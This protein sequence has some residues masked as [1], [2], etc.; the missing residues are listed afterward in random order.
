MNLFYTW[1]NF[2]SSSSVLIYLFETH[3]IGVI[4]CFK[5]QNLKK[6]RSDGCRVKENQT[7]VEKI[8]KSIENIKTLYTSVIQ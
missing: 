2:S 4:L 3:S 5:E 8:E 1:E 6:M 7:D